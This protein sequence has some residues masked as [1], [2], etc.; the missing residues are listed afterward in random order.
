MV[1]RLFMVCRFLG[2]CRLVFCGWRRRC[3]LWFL[4]FL[5]LCL[6]ALSCRFWSGILRRWIRL[7]MLLVLGLGRLLWLACGVMR[8]YVRLRCVV[9]FVDCV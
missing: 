4:L 6:R 9:V 7:L 2:L 8:L 1:M 5:V 3:M